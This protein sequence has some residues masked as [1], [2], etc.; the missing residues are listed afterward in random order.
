MEY[1][2]VTATAHPNIAFIKYWGNRD[3]YYRIPL[4]NS[5]SM[6]LDGLTTE[7]TVRFDQSMIDDKV[8]INN[9]PAS[10]QAS[11]RVS[12]ILDLIREI[13]QLKLAARVS[14]KNNFPM[15]S[16]IASSAS[17]FAALSLAASRAAG[18][19]LNLISLSRLARRGS[20]SACRSIPAGIVEWHAG[21]TDENSFA[22]QLVAPEHWDLVDCMAVTSEEHKLIGS[23]TGHQLASSSPLQSIRVN[24][25]D[26]RIKQCRMA[27]LNRDFESFSEVIE[28]DSNLMHSVMCTSRP[29]LVYWT[30][31][32]QNVIHTV[33]EMRQKGSEVA[34]TIDAGPNVHVITRNQATD[35]IKKTLEGISGVLRIVLAPVG[36]GATLVGSPSGLS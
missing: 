31:A 14:S 18:L 27:I 35:S 20:G 1:P 17:A 32:T 26:R 34:Y 36:A 13:A 6:N 23:S 21:D 24:D 25:A 2:S 33:R 4:Y 28:Q 30:E 11:K 16:G 22:E 29:G 7:T 19:S 10:L 3:D 9:Q 5:I 15:G 8:E 12:E